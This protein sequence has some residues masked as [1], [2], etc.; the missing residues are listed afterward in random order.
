MQKVIE[1]YACD[2]LPQWFVGELSSKQPINQFRELF[3]RM[4]Q[5]RDI[6]TAGN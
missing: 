2:Y 5:L 1:A 4:I 6:G 3:V